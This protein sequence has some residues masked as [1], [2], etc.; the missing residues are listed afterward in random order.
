M[1]MS[2]NSMTVTQPRTGASPALLE[3]DPRQIAPDPDNVRQHEPDGLDSLADSL[4][5]HGVLQPLGVS[6]ENGGYRVV[7]GSRRRT[8]AILAG[9]SRVPCVLVEGAPERRL[10]R[11]LVEN[12]QRQDLNDMDQAEGLARLRRD[13]VRTMANVSERDL[14]EATAKSVGLSVSTVRRYLNLRDL[15]APVRDL[16]A[17]GRLTVT[18][19]QHLSSIKDAARQEDVAHL[20]VERGLSAAAIARVCKA[21]AAR[22][23]L[24][25]V[26]A[27]AFGENDAELPEAAPERV[28]SER[29]ARA[30]KAESDDDSGLW[31]EPA[32]ENDGPVAGITETADGHRVFK[33][34]TVP[35]F[36]DEVDRIARAL[37]DGDLDRAAENDPAAPLKLR[38]TSRQLDHA[39]KLLNQLLTKRGWK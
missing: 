21:A 6:P 15:S 36:C 33:I 9:L 2:T 12:L 4:R 16:I 37:V 30:P 3:L 31:E 29:V 27:I 17:D 8:A 26:E 24:P 39:A 7:Y 1:T 23:N 34:R 38:L 25:V 20:A 11:Q 32:E 10:V 14:D 35:A 13:L 22:P 28:K 5:E 19:A 18:Q